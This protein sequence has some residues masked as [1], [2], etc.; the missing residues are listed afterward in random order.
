MLHPVEWVLASNAVDDVLREMNA[1]LR[2]RR[3]VRASG[4]GIVVLL[5]AA[6]AWYQVRAPEHA[7]IARSSAVVSLPERQVLPDGSVVELKPGAQIAVA[8]GSDGRRVALTAG[9]AHFQVEKQTVPFVVVVGGVEVRAV[10]TAFSVQLGSAEIEVVVT[11]GIVAVEQRPT[12]SGNKNAAGTSRGEASGIELA[13]VEAGNRILVPAPTATAPQPAPA[14]QPIGAGEI[15]AR[16]AWRAPRLEFSRT[17]LDQALALMAQ[18]ASPGNRVV[19]TL[20]DPS[21]AGVKVSGVLRADNLETLL[22]L[23]DEEHGIRSENVS[24]TETRLRR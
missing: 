22:R 12:F 16:L 10:G 2:R 7:G 21:L 23:L 1:R 9:E 14:V 17:P 4:G 20:A 24:P 11:E 6:L 5:L 19:V 13:R 18:H 3:R 15:A 8:F